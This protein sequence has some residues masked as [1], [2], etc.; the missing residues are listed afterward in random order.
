MDAEDIGF[1]IEGI[2]LPTTAEV[3]DGVAAVATVV[4]GEL[5]LGKDRAKTC[6]DE[7]GVALAHGVIVVVAGAGTTAVSDRVALKDDAKTLFE[8][9]HDFRSTG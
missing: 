3:F 2:F 1:E 5:A 4:K 9:G 6:R 7:E 8:A